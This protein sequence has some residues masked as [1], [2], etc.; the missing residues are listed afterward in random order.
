MEQISYRRRNIGPLTRYGRFKGR[1][2]YARRYT[3]G[4]RS[5]YPL[6]RNLPARKFRPS[7]YTTNLTTIKKLVGAEA[8]S[9]PPAGSSGAPKFYAKSFTFADLDDDTSYTGIYDAYRI[10]GIA[11]HIIPRQTE[12]TGAL[13]VKIPLY[14]YI[15]VDYDDDNTPTTLS[16]LRGSG[17]TKTFN[18]TQPFKMF[19]RPRTTGALWAGGTFSGYSVNRGGKVGPWIDMANTSV[20]YY[21]LK[22]GIPGTSASVTDEQYC[23]DI[24]YTYYIQLRGQR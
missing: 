18:L 20:K 9:W 22:I 10:Y 19:L 11:I 24:S 3:R 21:G 2:I 12:N 6:Y 1:S 8:I 7:S 4:W 23:I 5:S 14:G 15:T 13:A 16:S 17:Q